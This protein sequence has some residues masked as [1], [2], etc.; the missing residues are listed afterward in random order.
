MVRS[1]YRRLGS[2]P[3]ASSI[4]KS[5]LLFA[6]LLVMGFQPVRAQTHPIT[7]TVLSAVDNTTLPGVNIVEVGTQNGATTDFDGSFALVLSSPNASITVSFVGFLS[8]TIEVN[9]QSEIT[10][11]LEEDVAL[12]EEVVVTALG[13]ER[14]TRAVGFSVTAVDGEELRQSRENNVANALAGKVAGVLVQKPATGPAGSSRVVI[15]GVTSLTGD[16]NQ[17]LYVVDGIPM[18]N[19]Q[20]GNAGMWGGSDGGDGISSLNPDDIE[21]MSVLK[22]AAAAALYGSRAK[23]GVIVITTKKGAQGLGLGV[24]FNSNLTFENVLVN[25]D[26]QQ[27]YGQG[28]RAAAPETAQEARATNQSSWGKKLDGSSVIQWDGQQRPYSLVSDQLGR[29]YETGTTATNT[30]S[31]TGATQNSTVR[32]SMSHL[33]NDGISPSSGLERSTFSLRGT[34]NFGERFSADA[35]VNYIR[36]AVNNRPR[37][38]DSPGNANYS[39]YQLAPNVDPQSMKGNDPDNPGVASGNEGYT[40]GTELHPFGS[41]FTQNPY[42]AAYQHLQAD[43]QRRLIGFASLKYDFT[44]WLSLQGRVGL[45]NYST[46][47]TNLTPWGTAYSPLGGM[48]EQTFH[49]T[50]LQTDFLLLANKQITPKI[51]L[52][53]NLGGNIRW[54]QSETLTVSGSGGFN[55]PGLETVRNQQ[56]PAT[57][58]GYSERQINSLFGSAEVSYN[59]YLFVT[60][61]A[62]NDW[63]STLPIGNNSYFY[64]SISTSFVFTD[65][66]QAP[67]WL[68]F[69]K[70]RASWAEVGGDA[71]PY[72]LALTYS[73][74]GAAHLGN[75]YGGIAQGTIPLSSLKPFSTQEAEIGLDL[76]F[77]DNRFG[78]DFAWYD[79]ETTNQ[80]LNSTVSNSSGFNGQVINAGLITNTGVELL[81]STTPV[82]TA[83]WRWDLNFNFTKNKNEIKKLTEGTTSLT[84]AESRRRGNFVTA[85]EGEAYG[86]IKGRKYLRQNVPNDADGNPDQCN[87]T[88]PIVHDANGLPMRT[89]GVCV[90]GNGTPDFLGGIF[91]TVRYKNFTLNFL[92]DMRFGGEIFSYTNSQAYSAGLHKNTLEGREGLAFDSDGNVVGGGVTGDGV[93]ESG[94]P[95]TVVADPQEYFGRIG[96]QIGEAFV[97]DAGFVKLR[98]LSLTYR[99]PSRLFQSTP[100][101]VMSISLVGRNLW[102]INS[103]VP[104]VDPESN[105]QN[106]NAQGLEH[107][108]VPVTRSWG[109]N[110]NIRL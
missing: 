97:Y 98:E 82:R 93:D 65:A 7:G 50:E 83:D 2:T 73:L 45:D 47:R 24:E 90:L 41:I 32:L 86:T 78:I 104:N 29:F 109:F 42:W 53:G 43:E 4:V 100:I 28:T 110:F 14:E 67:S 60:A 52:S 54:N 27:Q 19:S 20:L 23:N 55:V 70:V 61:T 99:F 26:W 49:I 57:G 107:S 35:K 30:L 84:L 36:E 18:D 79:K 69:G 22:G 75:P 71:N 48:N 76:R 8:Q 74:A 38:S 59:G 72:Q 17:P 94:N 91:N 51:G 46:R 106:G 10:V 1:Y 31:L 13:I 15:R 9:G 81:L 58:Y 87:A 68:N 6:V 25:T 102:L 95:N 40:D 56:N 92:V 64:P 85:D 3:S 44:D 96:G 12:L 5:V 16:D 103:N 105:F 66:F 88:G 89:S 77:L 34:S 21:N 11:T 80:I 63:S 33:G 108:G 101:K 39:V 62:R 37:L